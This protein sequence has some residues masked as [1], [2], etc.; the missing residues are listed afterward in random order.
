MLSLKKRSN[1]LNKLVSNWA[2]NRNDKRTQ[3]RWEKSINTESF[4]KGRHKPKQKCVYD[5][6]KQ[7]KRENINGKCEYIEN[8]FECYI[9]KAP[10]KSHN[11]SNVETRHYNARHKVRDDKDSEN[12]N[13]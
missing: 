9:N 10:D 7:P 11:N 5:K 6:G 8:G 2:Y 4:N 1:V 13:E 12:R 3:E